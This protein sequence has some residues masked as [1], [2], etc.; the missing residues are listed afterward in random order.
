MQ[1]PDQ[2]RNRICHRFHLGLKLAVLRFEF[3]VSR[4]QRIKRFFSDRLMLAVRNWCCVTIWLLLP[5][6]FSTADGLIFF[7]SFFNVSRAFSS[8]VFTL[9]ITVLLSQTARKRCYGRP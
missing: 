4:L 2:L 5:A 1:F 3:A 8:L 7:F 6:F 9:G